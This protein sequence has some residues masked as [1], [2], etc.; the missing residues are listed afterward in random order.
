MP[1]AVNCCVRPTEMVGSLGATAIAWAETSP[2]P[3]ATTRTNTAGGRSRRVSVL[4]VRQESGAATGE[5][6]SGG[7]LHQSWGNTLPRVGP[8][9]RATAAAVAGVAAAARARGA[10]AAAAARARG[11]GA[12]ALARA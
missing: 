9:H 10:G 3:K 5:R 4:I 2:I 11:A 7:T 6:Q 8:L 12:A 1:V